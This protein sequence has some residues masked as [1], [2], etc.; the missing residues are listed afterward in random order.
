[1]AMEGYVR[2]KVET[3][4]FFDTGV[5]DKN[6][7]GFTRPIVTGLNARSLIGFRYGDLNSPFEYDFVRALYYNY[8]KMQ[9]RK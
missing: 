8:R 9:V 6:I 3:E 7:Y 5:F 4:L 2:R 1:M